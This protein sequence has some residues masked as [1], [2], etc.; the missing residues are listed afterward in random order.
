MRLENWSDEIANAKRSFATCL[1]AA[2]AEGVLSG[3]SVKMRFAEFRL[4]G[5]ALPLSLWFII[6]AAYYIFF[7][8]TLKSE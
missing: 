3:T 2:A 5:P 1:V 7:F 4:P 8:F 6:G